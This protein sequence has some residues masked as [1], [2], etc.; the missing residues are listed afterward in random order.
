MSFL[1]PVQAIE[2]GIKTEVR[3][4]PEVKKA[5]D[6]AHEAAQKVEALLRMVPA[7]VYAKLIQKFAA[8]VEA[9]AAA[10]GAH[11]TIPPAIIAEAAAGAAQLPDALHGLQ[12][13]IEV[14][15][16]EIFG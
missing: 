15:E 10:E 11:V 8:E 2:N 16:K 1:N 7:P 13:A 6:E 14:A 4:H 3:K 12:G 9:V 5:L